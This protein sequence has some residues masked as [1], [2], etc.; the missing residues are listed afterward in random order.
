[1]IKDLYNYI[2]SSL[3]TNI[4][5]P[6]TCSKIRDE[7]TCF[8]FMMFIGINKY[9]ATHTDM[10]FNVDDVMFLWRFINESITY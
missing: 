6:I 4:F 3:H 10:H 2:F 8:L 5:F 7:N 1:M 9:M